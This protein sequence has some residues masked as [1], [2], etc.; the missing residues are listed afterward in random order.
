MA[1]AKKKVNPNKGTK[2]E[3]LKVVDPLCF[4]PTTIVKFG[5]GGVAKSMK[6]HV[7]KKALLVILK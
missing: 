7:G 4:Y 3:I 6:K 1:K 5:N 2:V